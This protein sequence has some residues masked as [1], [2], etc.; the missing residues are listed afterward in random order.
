MN[1]WARLG[2][3]D[4]ALKLF[5]SLLYPAV[6]EGWQASGTYP[7]LFC[8]HP[9]FQIDGNFGGASGVAEMLMQSHR[10]S[11][12]LLPALPSEWSDGYFKGFRARGGFEVSLEWEDSKV[13]EGTITSLNGNL[14]TIRSSHPLKVNSKDST[15]EYLPDTAQPYQLTF[16]TDK[17]RTYRISP[18]TSD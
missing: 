2:D 10:G 5:R 17:G 11:I 1:F 15:S 6:Q 7:N 14:C 8:S 13:T 12:D 3:G 16:P 18:N 4:R 9:P